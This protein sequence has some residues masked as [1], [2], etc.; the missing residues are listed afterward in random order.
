MER[1]TITLYS[2]L[3][4]IGDI[5]DTQF[6]HSKELFGMLHVTPGCTPY[7]AVA[8]DT[9]GAWLGHMLAVI[10]RRGRLLPPYFYS[11]GQVTGEGVYRDEEAR[12]DCFPLL[13]EAV[14]RRFT[15]RLC[16]MVEFSHLST[17]M[18]GYRYF[19]QH[20]YVPVRWGNIHNSLHSMPPADRI[21]PDLQ[22]RIDHCYQM[23][24]ENCEATTQEDLDA[25]YRLLH[26]F[27]RFKF[28]RFIPKRQFFEAMRASDH[29]VILLTR[30]K[31]HV[32]GGCALIY[33][34]SD[35]YA[36]YAASRRKSYHK[37]HPRTMTTWYA[38]VHSHRMGKRHLRFMHVGLP[39]GTNKNREF[40]LEF[41]G[42]PTGTYRWF[43]C[44][45]G[46]V[47]KLM[48]WVFS[49]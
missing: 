44:S 19:R 21:S 32:I 22:Q 49:D 6:F 24:V 28:Q 23:G 35:A 4:E 31:G 29:A 20:G 12:E 30:Y 45:I 13:L 46:W 8:T 9:N 2:R 5:S 15:R 39:F 42:K 3:E 17:K 16:L 1:P 38:L 36:W 25:F 33:D 10:Y 48:R 34:R 43:R 40:L 18:F 47:N 14:T 37:Q 11:M 27:Y 41:G 26:N 7:M